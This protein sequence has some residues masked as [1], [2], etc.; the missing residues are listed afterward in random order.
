MAEKD[1]STLLR[2]KRNRR[3]GRMAQWLEA[4]LFTLEEDG[5]QV[6]ILAWELQVFFSFIV[7]FTLWL[8]TVYSHC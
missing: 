2:F 8:F 3:S 5:M 7:F 1:T 4:A 6:Q